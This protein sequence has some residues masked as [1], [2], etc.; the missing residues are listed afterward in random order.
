MQNESLAVMSLIELKTMPGQK[1][2]HLNAPNSKRHAKEYQNRRKEV[3]FGQ[4]TDWEERCKIIQDKLI[5][6]RD[7]TFV[8]LTKKNKFK[9]QIEKKGAKSS[10]INWLAL[11][12]AV[13]FYW[14]HRTGYK[15]KDKS[16]ILNG[17][18]PSPVKTMFS[19]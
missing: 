17:L 6:T 12:I 15:S 8:L 5:S 11:M 19:A 18:I 13:L 16:I 10:K 1:S 4:I 14:E 3:A 7:S 2:K 9:S